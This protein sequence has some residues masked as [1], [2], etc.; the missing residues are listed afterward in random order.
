LSREEAQHLYDEYKADHE[1]EQAEIF[2]KM[3]CND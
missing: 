3:H 2:F 1:K